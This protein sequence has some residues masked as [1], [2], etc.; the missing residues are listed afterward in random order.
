M[1]LLSIC[2]LLG[3]GLELS[4]FGRGEGTGDANMGQMESGLDDAI[5]LKLPMDEYEQ[6]AERQYNSQYPAE[7][8]SGILI[9]DAGVAHS[10]EYGD[11]DHDDDASAFD[12]VSDSELS[13]SANDSMLGSEENEENE[14]KLGAATESSKRLWGAGSG[15]MGA[16]R[17][18][19]SEALGA[20]GGHFPSSATA[21]GKDNA[22]S[23]ASPATASSQDKFH[24]ANAATDRLHKTPHIP[25]VA[26]PTAKQSASSH[27]P[28]QGF[29]LAARVYI[30]PSDK[31][32]HFDD[33]PPSIPYWDCGHKGSTTSPLPLRH[34]L[35]RHALS[36]GAGG[37]NWMSSAS[38]ASAT[39][40][41]SSGP[42]KQNYPVLMVALSPLV[43]DLNSGESQKFDAGSVILL[44][45]VLVPGHKMRP[46]HSHFEL[47]V[48][49]LTLPQQYTNTGKDHCSLPAT[50][51]KTKEDPCPDEHSIKGT[52]E[53]NERRD[54]VVR[55]DDE[56][57]ASTVVM[58]TSRWIG[59]RRARRTI[60]AVLGLSV[61]TL[62]A[63]FLGKTA[64]LWLAVG[65]GGTC[66]I[67]A[68]TWAV[69]VGG[70]ALLMTVEVWRE[71]RRLGTSMLSAEDDTDD[72]TPIQDIK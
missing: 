8:K 18:H 29:T 60:L 5:D 44:E 7:E 4:I 42:G 69:I 16:G 19:D 35:F 72:D 53:R 27:S 17:D 3:L 55:R 58:R 65:I 9:D 14:P 67:V 38:S 54:E 57:F 20:S 64:P 40:E 62:I 11:Y 23:S 21:T 51:L 59:A 68:T 22:A 49:F 45:D 37:S 1:K 63:D 12:T 39:S 13:S 31:L 70:D 43:I 46:L 30:D 25:F 34:A 6:M 50:V 56:N 28:P 32:A 41:F 52:V 71:R 33:S 15:S 48:M 36:G 47:S 66:F 2:L 24:E 61:S 26:K 10:D